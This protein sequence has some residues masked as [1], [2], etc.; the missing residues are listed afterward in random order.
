MSENVPTP[1]ILLEHQDWLRTLARRLVQDPATADD[2]VQETMA[3]ALTHGRAVRH[4]KGWLATV[5]R[6]R[7][8]DRARSHRRREA[9]EQAAAVP[10]ATLDSPVD[11]VERAELAQQMT[12]AVL[13]L[14]EPFRSTVLLRYFDGLSNEEIARR[15]D[16]PAATVRTRLK[17]ALDRL[18]AR[19]D[20]D[21]DGDRKRWAGPM[22]LAFGVES[23]AAAAS[24]AGSAVGAGRHAGLVDTTTV[25]ARSSLSWGAA[26]AATAIIAVVTT[27]VVYQIRPSWFGVDSARETGVARSGADGGAA[28]A[29]RLAA[30]STAPAEGAMGTGG[31]AAGRPGAGRDAAVAPTV[32]P[33]TVEL[34]G[35]VID[36]AGEPLGGIELV[37]GESWRAN[38]NVPPGSPGLETS[39]VSRADGSFRGTL[40][41][42]DP[43][44][45]LLV[46][47]REPDWETVGTAFVNPNAPVAALVIAGEVTV[48][49]GHVFDGAG[50]PVEG[51]SIQL[52]L[53]EWRRHAANDPS[54]T[55]LEI[56]H[57]TT[58]D[59]GEFV[60]DRVPDGLGRKVTAHASG[61]AQSVEIDPGDAL[62]VRIE[63]DPNRDRT[64]IDGFVIDEHGFAVEDAVV[65]H[66]RATTRTDR[67][68][69]FVLSVPIEPEASDRLLAV[70]DGYW[71][72]V[73]SEWDRAKPI[74]L[75][76]EQRPLELVGTL[77]PPAT[78][79]AEDYEVVL[80]DPT[81]IGGWKTLEQ[82]AAKRRE[83]AVRADGSFRV[84]GLAD[85][86]YTLRFRNRS[87]YLEFDAG[88]FAPSGAPLVVASPQGPY[89]T[90]HGVVVGLDGAP[91]EGVE[92]HRAVE[93]E[94]AD[95]DVVTEYLDV[96]TT[97]AEGRFVAEQMP[98]KAAL[99]QL[100]G[101][102]I[103]PVLLDLAAD[104][105]T[106][107]Y[108][109]ARR[110]GI[111][112]AGANPR[113][114]LEVLDASG[115]KLELHLITA[116]SR[117]SSRRMSATQGVITVAETGVRVRFLRNGEEIET[118]DVKLKPGTVTEI[119]GPR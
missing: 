37:V 19:F 111:R 96:D 8:R 38:S 66:G 6:N 1:E 79:S 119:S 68:G 105:T 15:H 44:V 93:Y 88:P 20:A 81:P 41:G 92:V 46:S 25:T 47:A 60:F 78:D 34:T 61:R 90:V 52:E 31:P 76:L 86:P 21:H 2:A 98:R 45:T 5:L 84:T 113:D 59:H 13:A 116:G 114:H 101:P 63:F 56:L 100:D 64:K 28:R 17:R 83:F 39:I 42:V 103:V 80:V 99:L 49:A 43:R 18:R 71:P 67:Q 82:W 104:E 95:G 10:E 65:V 40:A 115:E 62:G 16:V 35:R 109:I 54:N 117:T 73:A 87:T 11:V 7:V 77:D 70:A 27:M 36:V 57:T 72:T 3:A 48:V 29:P 33:V 58:N 23:S 94:M 74:E 91:I 53:D 75:R 14:D 12:A 107:E 102:T 97:D 106:V 110:C 4:V 51:V 26:V 112:I 55:R 22:A 30:P 69:R 89:R 118:V 50:R 85:R 24:G 9:R 108:A 32:E